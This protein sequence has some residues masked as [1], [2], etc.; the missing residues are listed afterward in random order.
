MN[1]FCHRLL[2]PRVCVRL[3][4]GKVPLGVLCLLPHP[5]HPH[6]PSPRCYVWVCPVSPPLTHSPVL[7]ER[8][9]EPSHCLSAPLVPGWCV[10]LRTAQFPLCT[11]HKR[12]GFLQSFRT[13]GGN[14]SF[15]CASQYVLC[16]DERVSVTGRPEGVQAQPV[17][18]SF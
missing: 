16:V 8:S 7:A 3:T 11:L 2:W 4:N 6:L 17:S 13:V 12:S 14:D 9:S 10:P 18:G 15:T 5:N 1:Y